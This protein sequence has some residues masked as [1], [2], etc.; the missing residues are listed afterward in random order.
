[1]HDDIVEKNLNSLL[2]DISPI[3][4]AIEASSYQNTRYTNILDS[5]RTTSANLDA[6]DGMSG[7]KGS[8][9]PHKLGHGDGVGDIG[10]ELPRKL[11]MDNP[12]NVRDLVSPS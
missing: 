9:H 6:V 8:E 11:F 12:S 7:K 2:N 10:A 1:M 3:A 5:A 4:H